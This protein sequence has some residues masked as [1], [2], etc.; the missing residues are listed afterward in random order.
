MLLVL[1]ALA[2]L[3]AVPTGAE[4][5]PASET[6]AGANSVTLKYNSTG[7]RI[8]HKSTGGTYGGGC[9]TYTTNTG[10]QGPGYCVNYDLTGV[11]SSKS[12]P[13]HKY[14]RNPKTMGAITN[15]YPQRT[16]EQ[17][18]SLHPDDIRGIDALTQDEYAY[19]TQ[20]A[21]WASC[22]Q[23]AVPGT[24]FTAGRSSI[25]EPTSDAQQIRVFD[26]VK[27]ILKLADGWTKQIY[28]GVY[29]RADKDVNVCGIEV[30]HPEGLPGAAEN[31]SDGIK[32]ET[33]N[34]V[35]YYTHV[36]CVA[37]ATTPWISGYKMSVF[38]TDAPSGTIFVAENNSLL[39][40]GTEDGV[41]SYKV[42]ISAHR[43]TSFNANGVEYYGVFKV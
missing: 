24:A 9:Y 23:I 6:L 30:V 35:E 13:I 25:V 15:G 37:S 8:L 7:L 33:I 42:D 2:G 4:E 14:D 12:L 16:L 10:L 11:S 29:L 1:A 43:Q 3:L 26:S 40:T 39:E 19:A 32:K 36:A 18:K 22:G 27:A 20:V 38:S 28:S 17:F 31:D 21:V 41:T 5:P 34:G